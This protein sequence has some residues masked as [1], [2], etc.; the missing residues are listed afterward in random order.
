MYGTD[1]KVLL[2]NIIRHAKFSPIYISP[3]F[4]IFLPVISQCHCHH[5]HAYFPYPKLRQ[6]KAWAL[7]KYDVR[8]EN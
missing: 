8:Y 2:E 3:L 1:L 5:H 7:T 4:E 6:H